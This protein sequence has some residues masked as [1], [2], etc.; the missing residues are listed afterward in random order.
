MAQFRRFFADRRGAT[1][2]EYAMVAGGV[3]L[4][5]IGAVTVLGQHVGA[6]FNTV[7]ASPLH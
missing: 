6:L 1:A 2:I 7:A 5:I 4:V 3:A